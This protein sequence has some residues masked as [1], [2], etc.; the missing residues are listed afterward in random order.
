MRQVL[1]S[2]ENLI[3]TMRANL[4]AR[5]LY[6]ESAARMGWIC[7]ALPR[8]PSRIVLSIRPLDTYWASATR[9]AVS[10][11]AALPDRKAFAQIAAGARS[12]RSVIEDLAEACPSSQICILPF[13]AYSPSPNLMLRDGCAGP[14]LPLTPETPLHLNKAPTAADLASA[15]AARGETTHRIPEPGEPWSPFTQSQTDALRERYQDDLFWLA[16][17]ADGRAQF[18][19]T[20][21]PDEDAVAASA[22]TTRRNGT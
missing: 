22:G 1:I 20:A 7:H 21:L 9:F 15:L 5:S 2:D 14:S 19:E 3:G 8:P 17:G 6:P 13:E 16:Q 11:G 12:W 10:R 4:R 18:I